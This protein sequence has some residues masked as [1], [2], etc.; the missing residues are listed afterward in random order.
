MT[1][2]FSLAA[3]TVA[4]I[5]TIPALPAKA[6]EFDQDV[7]NE[8]ING[9]GNTNGAFTTDRANSVEVGLRAKLRHNAAG[10]P[11]NTFN[12]NGDGTY[13]FNAGVAPTQAFPTGEWSFEWSINSDY[14]GGGVDLSALTYELSMMST[15]VAVIV[16]F[17]PINDINIGL[18]PPRVQWDHGIGDNTTGNGGGTVIPN[19]ADDAAGYM[20][21]IDNNNLA[22]NSWKPHWFAP[23]FNPEL[24]G[25]YTFSLSASDPAGG[26]VL[27]RTSIT[28][29]VVPEPTSLGL[30]SI[31]GLCGLV[32][33]RRRSA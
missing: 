10:A 26:G 1:M 33:L 15:N 8:F 18:V 16:P 3:L 21:L 4:L 24:I 17:D 6:L 13:T 20:T 7:T 12:S 5:A 30:L 31:A 28:V 32:G 27:A 14:N 22:Q 29:N 9:S 11:E 2:R 25:D 23:A 19:A